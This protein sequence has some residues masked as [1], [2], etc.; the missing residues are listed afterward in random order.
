MRMQSLFI[1]HT[2]ALA[3]LTLGGNHAGFAQT[4]RDASDVT[5]EHT[6]AVPNW[7]WAPQHR[8]GHV[9]PTTCYFRKTVQLQGVKQATL[10]IAGDDQ[11]ELH[12]NGHLIGEGTSEQGVRT[13]NVTRWTRDG[14]NTIAVKVVNQVGTTAGLA[15]RLVVVNRLGRTT[16]QS[17]DTSWKTSLSPTLMWTRNAYFDARWKP[18]IN[19][20]PFSTFIANQQAVL[21][22]EA[23]AKVDQPAVEQTSQDPVSPASLRPLKHSP[24]DDSELTAP[25]DFAVEWLA[26]N[27]DLG[28]VTAI[29]FDSQGQPIVSREDGQLWILV[30]RD[31][32][33]QWDAIRD[34]GHVMKT[35]QGLLAMD[36]SIYV[37][38]LGD[39]GLGLYRL[40]DSSGDGRFDEATVVVPFQGDNLEHG[41]HG[42][43]LGP[44]GLLYVMVGNHSP[45]KLPASGDS[46]YRYKYEGDLLRPR[47]QDPGGHA[48]GIEAPGGYLLRT[49]REGKKVEIVAGGFRNAYDLAFNRSGA[50]F[51]HDSDME[52]DRGT[53]WYRPTRVYQV[54]DGAE[55]GWRSGWAKWPDYFLDALPGIADTGRGSPTGMVVYNHNA[56]PKR[57][58][59]TLFSCDWSEGRIWAIR[60][61]ERGASLDAK[62]E[63]FIKG[64]PLNVTDIEV[65]PDG[66]LYFATGGRG[67]AGNLYRVVWKGVSSQ[68]DAESPEEIETALHQPQLNSA[69][70]AHILRP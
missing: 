49:D 46:P 51:T 35:C 60:Y 25:S 43:A 12:I 9:P 3:V 34:G 27:D 61:N 11:F 44:D 32:D 28:S 13:F 29:T 62:T 45:L 58:Q 10:A 16:V 30:D 64:T 21:Q 57:Y 1:G 8:V 7:I 15:A 39:A 20:G 41:P 59:N 2:I 4:P 65:G 17:T 54:I 31:H 37:T 50:L 55:F 63:V 38:G 26:G 33:K 67:T 52:S 48:T 40:R 69:W 6:D 24:R 68:S 18:A 70:A 19:F 66:A 23:T 5:M 47:Y 36:D 56:F 53:T 42:I 14:E 22:R